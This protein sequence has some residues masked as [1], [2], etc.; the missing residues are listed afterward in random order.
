MAAIGRLILTLKLLPLAL[1]LLVP[2]GL[3]FF[4]H[5]FHRATRL[6]AVRLLSVREGFKTKRTL[7]AAHA[8]TTSS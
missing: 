7:V 4:I 5:D 6:T 2:C 8:P 3:L 1:L